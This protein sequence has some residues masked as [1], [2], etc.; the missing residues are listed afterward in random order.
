LF[1]S[2]TVEVEIWLVFSEASAATFSTGIDF[3]RPIL[4]LAHIVLNL[5][6]VFQYPVVG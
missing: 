4:D 5:N 2:I 1:I 6:K 3:G